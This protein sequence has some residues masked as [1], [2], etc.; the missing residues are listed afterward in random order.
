V[1]GQTVETLPVR[2]KKPKRGGMTKK[3]W[4]KARREERAEREQSQH[5]KE[6]NASV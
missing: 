6:S 5:A 1:L 2:R 3:E 4:K